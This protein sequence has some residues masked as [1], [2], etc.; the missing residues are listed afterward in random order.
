MRKSQLKQ[1]L[2]EHPEWTQ[3]QD[4]VRVPPTAYEVETEYPE[5]AGMDLL[6]DPGAMSTFGVTRLALYV[7]IRRKGEDH[8]WAVMLAS[9][10]GP[11]LNTDA[12]FFEG[13]PRL[14]EQIGS[15]RRLNKMLAVAAK[16]GF[17]PNPTDVYQPGLARFQG[18]PEA[19]VP[20]TG[21]RSYIRKLCEKR[22]WACE[23]AVKVKAAEPLSDPLAPENCKPLGED[24]I[25]DRAAEMVRKNPDLKRKS[26]RELREAVLE[27]HG[28]SK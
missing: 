8:K 7:S 5:S 12:T 24:I 17:K 26:R 22:G 23:G 18:D 25:R 15:Q 13:M 20:A 1:F 2:K 3:D 14:Y 27:K 16:H 9:Q 4:L 28:P 6:R 21:G 10:Q 19:F 11:A